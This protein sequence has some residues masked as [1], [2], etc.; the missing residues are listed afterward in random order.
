M[1]KNKR[2]EVLVSCMHASNATNNNSLL[3]TFCCALSYIYWSF[4]IVFRQGPHDTYLPDLE[5]GD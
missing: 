1:N 5:S 3:H 4:L 2:C